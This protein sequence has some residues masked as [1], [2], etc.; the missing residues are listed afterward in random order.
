MAT[1]DTALPPGAAGDSPP[2]TFSSWLGSE[3]SFPHPLVAL[4]QLDRTPVGAGVAGSNSMG[5]DPTEPSGKLEKWFP[6]WGEG[7]HSLKLF[8]IEV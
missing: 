4:R 3:P 7:A 2:F 5:T 1:E 8:C 6:L